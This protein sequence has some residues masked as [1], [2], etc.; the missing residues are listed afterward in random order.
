MLGVLVLVGLVTACLPAVTPVAVDD[1]CGRGG[2]TSGW[3]PSLVGT[4]ARD[5]VLVGDSLTFGLADYGQL[6]RLTGT[7]GSNL[8]LADGRIGCTAGQR[9]SAVQW[10]AER[11]PDVLAVE[12]GTN[13]VR[14]ASALAAQGDVVAALL[15]ILDAQGQ[16]RELVRDA[17]TRGVSCVVLVGVNEQAAGAFDLA[18]YGPALNHTM[19]EQSRAEGVRYADWSAASRTQ[20]EWFVDDGVHLTP[21][22]SAAFASLIGDAIGRC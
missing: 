22:G 14:D 17:R 3:Q 9:A 2:I 21:A 18:R 10:Y 20:P 7:N 13:D 8:L 6:G 4:P 12:L 5:V 11:R 19:S 15:T 1:V 16:I